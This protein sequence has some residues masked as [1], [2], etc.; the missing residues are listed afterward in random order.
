[1]LRQLLNHVANTPKM[2]YPYSIPHEKH[3]EYT[4]WLFNIA[5]VYMALI[6]IDGL[7]INSTVDLSSS[8]TGNVITKLA[9]T[10]TIIYSTNII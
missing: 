7:P 8:R 4:L 1:M 5:M 6:E 2:C 9:F 10:D 3:G